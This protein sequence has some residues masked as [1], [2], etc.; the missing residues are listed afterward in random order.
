MIIQIVLGIFIIFAVSRVVLQ[1]KSGNLSLFSFGFWSA[2]FIFG[3][4]GLAFPELLTRF[5]RLVGIGR[6]VDAAIYASILLL[7]YLVFRLHVL[8]EDLRQ[9]VVGILRE[10]ALQKLPSKKPRA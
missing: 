7:F 8:L 9:E 4:V 3:L 10:I 5:A 6:G 2:L 1:V